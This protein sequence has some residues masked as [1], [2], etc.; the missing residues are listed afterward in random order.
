MQMRINSALTSINTGASISDGEHY[1]AVLER[2]G[3]NATYTAQGQSTTVSGAQTGALPI[4]S[5]AVAQSGG[6]YQSVQLENLT[7]GEYVEYRIDEG[8]G[9]VVKAYD[10][11]GN[12]IG[13]GPNQV[14]NGTFDDNLDG[15]TFDNSDPTQMTTTWDAG[16]MRISRGTGGIAGNPQQV[17][18]PNVTAGQ[19][20]VFGIDVLDAR[21]QYQLSG[22]ASSTGTLLTGSHTI[23][24][25]AVANNAITLSMWNTGNSESCR[26]DNISCNTV[27]TGTITPDADW[28]VIP[29]QSKGDWTP[30]VDWQHFEDLTKGEWTPDAD[31]HH[32]PRDDVGMP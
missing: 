5:I 23:E 9:T 3:S 19:R 18:S 8:S 1:S 4:N 17:F 2:V 25:V 29:D 30:D 16:T 14:T 12:V 21:I 7:T 32:C 26:V 24:L 22:G 27:P 15:W 20:V 10:K 31:W 28:Q 6:G 11:L 13:D